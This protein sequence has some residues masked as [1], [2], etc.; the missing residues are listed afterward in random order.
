M[1]LVACALA[2]SGCA[3]AQPYAEFAKAGTAYSGALDKLL[4]AAGNV[5]LDKTS[6]TLISLHDVSPPKLED[7]EKKNKLDEDRLKLIGDLRTHARLLAKYFAALADLAT[8]DAPDRAAA[9]TKTAFEN[10]NNFSKSVSSSTVVSQPE[11]GASLTKLVVGGAIRAELRAELEARKD[12]IRQELLL[13]DALIKT[14]ASQIGSGLESSNKNRMTRLVIEPLTAPK[15][16][17]REEK[18]QLVI[19]RRGILSASTTVAELG[20]ATKAVAS[21]RQSFEALVEGRLTLAGINSLLA[22]VDAV[23]SVAEAFND[24]K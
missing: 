24:K 4:V 23:V 10:L 20:E 1:P 17:S 19:D 11:A 22:D 5:Q 9:S 3:S 14:L 15:K 16:L 21:L 18:D 6:E 7:V 8:T 2:I 12:A 13:Q